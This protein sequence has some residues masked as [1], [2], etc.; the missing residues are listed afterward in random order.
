MSLFFLVMLSPLQK[1]Q[2]VHDNP[3]GFHDVLKKSLRIDG[4]TASLL[5]ATSD[6][7]LARQVPALLEVFDG[8]LPDEV[9][10]RPGLVHAL[11]P[12]M[13][14]DFTSS[15]DF[16]CIHW[17]CGWNLSTSAL[18]W[19]KY[20]TLFF[21]PAVVFEGAAADGEMRFSLFCKKFNQAACCGTKYARAST[22]RLFAYCLASLCRPMNPRLLTCIRENIT[23][24]FLPYRFPDRFPATDL[25]E[26]FQDVF[27]S[28]FDEAMPG[29]GIANRHCTLGYRLM[30][31]YVCRKHMGPISVLRRT[32]FVKRFAIEHL[33]FLKQD[34][35]FAEVILISEYVDEEG[36]EAWFRDLE[37]TDPAVV[38]LA[39]FV[40]ELFTRRKFS[41]SHG[42]WWIRKFLRTV[43]RVNI[44]RT[45]HPEMFDE[46]V[47][48][49]LLSPAGHMLEMFLQ[50][51]SDVMASDAHELAMTA[52]L[53]EQDLPGDWDMLGVL[54]I[55][56]KH[57]RISGTLKKLG[58][59]RAAAYVA[60]DESFCGVWL[61]ACVQGS[62]EATSNKRAR[63]SS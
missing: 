17:S 45:M 57:Y 4:L 56:Q 28:V 44:I 62:I 58:L 24:G 49:L 22:A 33:D 32:G 38:N 26:A 27:P 23:D 2:A 51:N 10:Q 6:E 12:R 8:T 40:M 16:F 48:L 46:N 13:L 14:D 43:P 59:L 7:V 54:D 25:I 5:H 41:S 42:G 60:F 18:L 50:K 30:Q 3:Y 52:F 34:R 47:V 11:S 29:T 1:L 39:H 53:A 31:V 36:E 21:M 35:A 63:T 19:D 15:N 55:L 37:S 61:F 20:G 9:L